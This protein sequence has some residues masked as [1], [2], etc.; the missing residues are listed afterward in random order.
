MNVSSVRTSGLSKCQLFRLVNF[1][2]GRTVA[3]VSVSNFQ[4][5]Q[6]FKLSSL[7]TVQTFP[8]TRHPPRHPLTYRAHT[9]TYVRLQPTQSWS[10]GAQRTYRLIDLSMARV[11]AVTSTT[12]PCPRTSSRLA[13]RTP[14]HTTT[15]AWHCTDGRS[16]RW[17]S[18]G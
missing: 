1:S 12:R 2:D 9:F 18:W 7:Y 3:L 4:T 14:N 8:A 17:V 15:N 16:R 5:L 13:Y 11:Y 10:A 6:A